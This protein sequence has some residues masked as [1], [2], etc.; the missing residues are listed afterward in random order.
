M[1]DVLL[2]TYRPNREWLAAQVASIRS[3][4]GVS[5]R[6][7]QREDLLGEGPRANFDA[8][9]RESTAD[10]VAFADQDDVWLPEKLS[11]SLTELQALEKAYGA[12]TPLAVFTDGIVADAKLSPL[13]GTVMSRQ[14]VDIRGGSAFARLLMQNFIAGCAML[15]NAALRWKVGAIPEN[16]HLHDYWVV[17]VAAAFG[18]IGYVDEPLYLYRQHDRNA[19]GATTADLAHFI[20]RGR[21]GVGAFRARLGQNIALAQA[22]VS[23]FGEGAPASAAALA[24]FGEMSYF[25]RRQA[26]FRNHLFKQGVLRNLALVAF[27]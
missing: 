16:V 10:Y 21:E 13:P 23:R 22:F 20:R 12:D 4:R 11:K 27:A 15:F 25:E 9:L 6:L 17:L 8:L 14:N 3:Q 26:L 5:I 2:A 24:R 1:I 19:V 18:R 7:L